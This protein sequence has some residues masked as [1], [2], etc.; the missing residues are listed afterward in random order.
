MIIRSVAMF[1]LFAGAAVAGFP[2]LSSPPTVDAS[3]LIADGTTLYT[4][5]MTVSDGDGY[6]DIRDIR[7]LL[8]YS[9][10]GGDSSKGRGYLAWGP[11]DGDI[12]RFGG[13]WVLADAANGGRW[14]YNAGA[15]GGTTY[16]SPAGCTTATSG[17]AGGGTGSR[18]VTWTFAAKPAWA[19]NPL[20]ND[21]DAWFADASANSGWRDTPASF[22]VVAGPCVSYSP[23]PRAPLAVAAAARG[24]DVALDPAESSADLFAI[25]ILPGVGGRVWLQQDGTMGSAPLWLSRTAWGTKHVEGLM[26]ATTCTV[27]ARAA[28]NQP[29]YCP[30]DF[31][32][33][34][35]A[36]TP[37]YLPRLHHRTGSPF[38]VW[39]R[40]QC[41]YRQIS[42]TGYAQLWD[43][44]EGSL[45]RGL[46]GGLDADTYD[47][48]DI[49]SGANW[50][51]GGGAFTT[52]EFLQ[53]SRDHQASPMLTANVFGGG[54]KDEANQG[55]FVCQTDNP[56]AL[57]ADW[58]RYT[59]II[60][61]N[62]RQGQEAALSGENLRVYSSIANWGGRAILLAAGEPP[63]PPVQH[64]EIGNEPEVPGIHPMLNN[65]YLSPTDYRDRYKSMSQA[66]RA[67]DPSLKFGPCLTNPSDPNGQW[68]PTLAADP[69]VPI[70]FISYHPYYSGIKIAWGAPEAMT[71]ALRAMK[72]T[73][74]R[75]SG[76]I[77]TIM[78]ARGRTGYGLIASEW[79][80]VNWDA[81]GQMQ[82][83][84]ANAL[85]VAETVF[86]FAED[87]VEG[88]TFWEQPQSKLG[89][90][91]MFEGLRDYMGDTLLANVESMGLNPAD[92]NWRIYA[93]KNA[94]DDTRLMIWG[95]NFEDE[96]TVS[97]DLSIAHCRIE[98][99]R[100][101]RYGNPA[102]DT[103]LM[104]SS[105][106]AW[107]ETAVAGLDASRFPLTMQDAEAT[108]LVLDIQPLPKV[109]FDLDGD[110]DQADFGRFQACLTGS[111]I[112]VTA[113]QCFEAQLDGDDDV[114]QA[115]LL[116]FA[117]CFTGPDLEA[118]YRCA[119]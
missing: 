32:P 50:G 42:T 87:G 40:G 6:T 75:V 52:L 51:L 22:D 116:L 16:I 17:N 79:N 46:A 98:S 114:D 41:P 101:R 91:H 64:W 82:R 36:T 72:A 12:T 43:I 73:L 108:I 113:P 99:A 92:L 81:A 59:N 14:G 26:W 53:N 35:T 23:A 34:A 49:A 78:T 30:S 67:V 48:R 37:A 74:N 105:G 62:Y 21:A 7:T 24:L 13:E 86:T 94:D 2:E 15:W 27:Q 110:V 5:S 39:V 80:P 1:L 109:D 85:G 76:S 104:T 96:Q 20:V 66:M 3:P 117:S 118:D 4:L 103:S 112:P 65:H 70:D 28:R 100:L 83:S 68:L 18:T 8:N 97:V 57:A 106:M 90:K 47:W 107:T 89:P 61:Q 33:P 54:Y 77:R 119:D 58:V 111:T 19:W 10:A 45:A 9:E 88:S 84:V 11:T 69:A 102:G 95:L 56:E 60:L 115:D 93:T 71:D 55:V 38:N 29:G 31:G 63:V 44:T 25:R